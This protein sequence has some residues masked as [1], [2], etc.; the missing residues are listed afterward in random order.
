MGDLYRAGE[1]Y[2]KALSSAP[3]S[4][5]VHYFHGMF[6]LADLQD[7]S[8]AF[9]HFSRAETLDPKHPAVMSGHSECVDASRTVF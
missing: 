1:A 4:A 7:Y 6:L 9:K 3:E 2:D 5:R 8:E